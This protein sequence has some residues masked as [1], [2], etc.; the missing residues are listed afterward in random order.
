MIRYSYPLIQKL[1]GIVRPG[2]TILEMQDI[3]TTH[4]STFK[5]NLQRFMLCMFFPV[6][7]SLFNNIFLKEV[8]VAK[9]TKFSPT[10]D[11]VT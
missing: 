10:W 6:V 11:F 4:N 5:G 3:V 7:F 2:S 8:S 9:A 1:G